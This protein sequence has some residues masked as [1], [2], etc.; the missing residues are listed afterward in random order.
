VIGG[1]DWS[2]DRLLP[3][4]VRGFLAGEVVRIR[5]PGSVRPWQHVLEP[6]WGYLRLAEALLA[7]EGGA[8]SAWNFGPLAE[9]AWP[10]AR[11]AET[12]ADVWGD[13]ARWVLDAEPCVHE[14]GYLK[15]DAGKARAELGWQPALRLGDALE[16]LVAWYRAHAAGNDMQAF[17]LAQIE[18]YEALLGS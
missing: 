6:L 3:D 13:S 8:A 14:A 5:R 18:A 4:L 17:T 2:D 9:D 11:I 12:M 10:V 16:W 1:G 15:L 7:D